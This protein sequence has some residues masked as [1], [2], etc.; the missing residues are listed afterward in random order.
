MSPL[1]RAL[2]LGAP[3]ALLSSCGGGSAPATLETQTGSLPFDYS[4][5]RPGSSGPRPLLVALASDQMTTLTLQNDVGNVLLAATEPWA[6]A[7]LDIPCH[8]AWTF[9]GARSGLPGWGD[10]ALLGVDFVTPLIARVRLMI[11]DLR[12][13]N[14]AHPST[15]A[16]VGVSRGG[17]LAYHCAS[18]GVARTAAGIAPVTKL[19]AL[20]E[21]AGV[22]G[23]PLPLDPSRLASSSVFAAIS[24]HDTRVGT[25]NC[26]GFVSQVIAGQAAPAAELHITREE[27][28][29]VPNGS[30]LQAAQ[31]IANDWGL[32]L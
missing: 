14:I 17:F 12:T 24:D 11:D 25:L 2:V 29:L 30:P 23:E 1:R 4:V 9:P 3:V 20:T 8:G 32:A 21:F 10:L 27:G 28:H 18:A 31:F 13:K 5:L 6:V 26:V 7:S 15:V 19:S 22:P 16:L